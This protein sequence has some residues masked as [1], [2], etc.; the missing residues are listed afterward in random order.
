MRTFLLRVCDLLLL[1]AAAASFGACLTSILTTDA[2]GWVVPDAPYVPGRA[3]RADAGRTHSGGAP[4]AGRAA[5][6]DPG[7]RAHRPLPG[8][9]RARGV[10]Q[11]LGAGRGDARA[12]PGAVAPGAAHR[13]GRGGAQGGIWAVV[14]AA[15]GLG[16]LACSPVGNPGM[17]RSFP[18]LR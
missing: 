8:A 11:Y 13:T 14:R 7:R 10:W 2:Y 5:G 17:S 1:G 9:A 6:G 3:D 15:R 16:Q 4:V 18:Y 12:V